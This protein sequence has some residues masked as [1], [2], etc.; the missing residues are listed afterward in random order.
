MVW[1]YRSSCP[2]VPALI[3]RGASRASMVNVSASATPVFH[4]TGAEAGR[5]SDSNA[6][7]SNKPDLHPVITPTQPG[8]SGRGIPRFHPYPAMGLRCRRRIGG[9]VHPLPPPRRVRVCAGDLRHEHFGGRRAVALAEA[10]TS[11]GPSRSS[12]ASPR[13]PT[14]PQPGDA[15]KGVSFGSED[16]VGQAGDLVEV[17]GSGVQDQFVGAQGLELLDGVAQ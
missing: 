9:R 1:V 12:T 4:A 14:P 15:G 10:V 6:A 16:Y 8:L 7:P 3:T 5:L 11:A 2:R 13:P 17:V